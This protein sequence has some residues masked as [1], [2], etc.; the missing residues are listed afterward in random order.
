MYGHYRHRCFVFTTRTDFLTYTLP[1]RVTEFACGVLAARL[2]LKGNLTL[3]YRALWLIAF[4]VI[5][6]AGRVMISASVLSLSVHYYNIFKVIGYA[7]MGIG[8][9]GMLYLAVTSTKWLEY[10]PGQQVV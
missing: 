5:V 3:K 4:I 7:L 8:F 9:A 1:F 10:Y 6:Y 2:L